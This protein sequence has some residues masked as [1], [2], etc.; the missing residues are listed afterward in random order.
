MAQPPPNPMAQPP[1]PSPRPAAQSPSDA[2]A[3]LGA[4]AAAAA[5]HLREACTPR[6]RAAFQL[7]I[8]RQFSLGE[9][10]D[11]LSL[12]ENE[13]VALIDRVVGIAIAHLHT[14]QPAPQ[15]GHAGRFCAGQ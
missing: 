1:K 4:L 5:A 9:V 7:Y 8:S 10:A 12:T 15:T 11:A 2:A 14:R 6:E 13:V 3:A